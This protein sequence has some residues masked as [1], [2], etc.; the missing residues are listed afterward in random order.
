MSEAIFRGL[1]VDTAPLRLSRGRVATAESVAEDPV[2]ARTELAY[3]EA[4]SAGFAEGLRQGR[5][6]GAAA[7][8]EEGARRGREDAQRQVEE[9]AARAV[10][11]ATEA[12]EQ[13]RSRLQELLRRGDGVLT[14]CFAAA[15]DDMVALCYQTICRIVG[16]VAMRPESI[17][18][19]LAQAVSDAGEQPRLFLQVH[20]DDMALLER[21]G[22]ADVAGEAV[23]WRGDPGVVLGG[24]I[25]RS[26]GGGLDAR[27]ET[28]LAGCRDALLRAR[29]ARRAPGTDAVEAA[30]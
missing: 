25:V 14:D 30:R 12:L 15:E 7:G 19:A 29:D 22:L 5:Q 6:E 9:E 21:L 1:A 16:D 26:P 8:Y 24:C 23:A 3:S 27:L 2:R 13:D 10:T 20:A 18:A 28:V 17:R 11:A 4:A